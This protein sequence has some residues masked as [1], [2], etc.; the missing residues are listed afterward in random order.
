MF[1]NKILK[2]CHFVNKVSLVASAGVFHNIIDLFSVIHQWIV[3]N[4]QEG[5]KWLRSQ[6][7]VI[8]TNSHH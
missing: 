4:F 8:S 1:L 3:G 2:K 5:I 7:V 6:C